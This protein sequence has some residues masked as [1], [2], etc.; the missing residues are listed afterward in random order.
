MT[1]VESVD[2]PDAVGILV[3]ESDPDLQWRLARMLTVQGHRV[4]AAGTADG[5]RALL[6]EWGC[7]LV[8]VA[9]HLHGADG[10]SV[11]EDLRRRFPDIPVVLMTKR[12]GDSV[13]AAATRRGISATIARPF[14]WETFRDVLASLTPAPVR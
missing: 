9:E 5:A 10:M 3:L 6:A 4:V 11:A 8:L 14:R 7:D 2:R 12:T 1:P 13:R